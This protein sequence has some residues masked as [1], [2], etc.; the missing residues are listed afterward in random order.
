MTAFRVAALALLPTLAVSAPGHRAEAQRQHTPPEVA[1]S[2]GGA[3]VITAAHLRELLSFIASDDT[4]GRGTPSRGLD[5][6]ARFIASHLARW[7]LR[8]AVD[9][10][11]YFQRIGLTRARIDPST[12]SANVDGRRFS[13]GPD[14]IVNVFPGT[15][16]GPLVY[17]GHGWVIRSKN[18]DSYRGLD[19][20]DKI[21][22]VTETGLPPGVSREDLEGPQGD[23][24]EPPQP[25]LRRRG[26][27]AMITVPS[28]GALLGWQGRLRDGMEHGLLSM[29]ASP[30][31]PPIPVVR[32]SLEMFQALLAGEPQSALTLLDRAAA[33][34]PAP[35]F[36]LR[37]AKRFELQV[38]IRSD[39]SATQ[40]VIA[41]LEG[42]DPTLKQEYVLVGAHYDHLGIGTPVAGD[43]IYNGADDDG[44]G[45]AAVMA[46]AEAFGRGPRPRR[47]MLFIWHTGEERQR[48]G[49]SYFVQ[50]PTVPLA[51]IVAAL[52]I[53][54]IG[55]TR[56]AGTD[57]TKWTVVRPGELYV[58]GS[59][60]MSRELGEINE[61]VNRSYLRLAL[62]YR[63]DA[64]D[65][66]S[67]LFS[68]SDQYS[69]AEKGIPVIFYYGGEHE[70]YHRPSD[71]ADKID[72]Q[73]LQAV[74]RTVY[75]T[76]W[77]L[78]NRAKRPRVDKSP[79]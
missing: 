26:A 66:P 79:P 29:T 62:N 1:P 36:A 14:F 47:S 45:T 13:F 71:T 65:D 73:H 23:D 49:S 64:L 55:R 4:E 9:D 58:I 5:A 51:Q 7:K 48:W 77:E 34:D 68:R 70:D 75:A 57:S 42:S 19:V 21:V 37:P 61:A 50:H 20:R 78:A 56:T 22:I 35:P 28:F 52:N 59:R 6:T 2:R 40:N 18:I 27:S 25:A 38:G 67:Q 63:F 74:A 32:P 15:F 8:S 43:S 3:G 11:S 41:V 76:A 24:W 31:R 16:A 10:G 12:T 39:S 72:Y 53:D 30:V 69:Y 33:G 44:S 46:I 54:M 60:R 17:V